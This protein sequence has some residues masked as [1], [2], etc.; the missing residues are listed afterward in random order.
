MEMFEGTG[1]AA[2]GRRLELTRQVI[3]VQQNEF[4]ERARIATNTYNQYER[5]KKRPSLENALKLCETYGLT[6]D[7]IYRGDPSALRY[8]MADAIKALK[9][10]RSQTKTRTRLV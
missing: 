3:G 8:S 10:E 4:C 2:I 1:L 6:L 7:W 9:Q 5:G